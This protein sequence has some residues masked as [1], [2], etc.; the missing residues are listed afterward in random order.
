M[1]RATYDIARLAEDMAARGWLPAELARRAGVSKMTVSRVLRQ[2]AQTA[3]TM[4]KLA[5]A[6]GYSTRRYLISKRAA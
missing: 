5:D 4:A 1:T 3:P 2:A 6:L